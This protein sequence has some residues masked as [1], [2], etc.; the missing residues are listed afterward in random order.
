MKYT[1]W[2]LVVMLYISFVENWNISDRTLVYSANLVYSNSA[3]LTLFFFFLKQHRATRIPVTLRQTSPTL[4]PIF[5]I[6]TVNGNWN[7][8]KYK[9][10]L[11]FKSCIK[12]YHI[13]SLQSILWTIH[14]TMGWWVINESICTCRRNIDQQYSLILCSA[15]LCQV[16]YPG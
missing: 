14:W 2:R 15:H 8:F 12:K 9:Y 10:I 13:V 7:I 11:I 1:T 16:L 4:I 6:K 5:K 3:S